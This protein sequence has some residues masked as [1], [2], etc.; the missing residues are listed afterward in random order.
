MTS[1][2]PEDP[3][4]SRRRKLVAALDEQQ[5]VLKALLKG[6]A[7]SQTKKRWVKGTGGERR[8][9]EVKRTVQPWFWERDGGWYVHC[10]YGSR[11]L[12]ISGK[13]NAV[14][15]T[16]LDEVAAVLDTLAKAAQA[17]ELDKAINAVTKAKAAKAAA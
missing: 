8:Q 10:K 1:L 17:G 4:K 3:V 9:E 16:K 14:F 13:N 2:A 5:L 11:T 15:V 12:T 6:D 7:H